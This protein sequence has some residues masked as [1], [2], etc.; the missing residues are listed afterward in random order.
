MSAAVTSAMTTVLRLRSK[1]TSQFMGW[2]GVRGLEYL[3][4]RTARARSSRRHREECSRE[5]PSARLG[6]ESEKSAFH[7][8]HMPSQRAPEPYDLDPTCSRYRASLRRSVAFGK[9]GLNLEHW[10]KIRGRAAQFEFKAHEGRHAL[11]ASLASKAADRGLGNAS[12]RW[13]RELET[14]SKR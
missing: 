9:Y 8:C 12:V 13:C 1:S 4:S 5:T 10:E 11:D 3:A 6:V 7:H 2:R 14:V